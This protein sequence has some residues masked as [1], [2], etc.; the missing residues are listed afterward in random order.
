[1]KKGMAVLGG[2][3]LA[4]APVIV[5]AATVYTLMLPNI[6]SSSARISVSGD[7]PEIDPFSEQESYYTAYNPFFQR[8]QFEIIQSN[9]ILYE[10]INRLNL[11]QEW[12]HN[13]EKLPREVALKI[14]R[15]SVAVFQQRDTSLMVISVKRDRPDEAADIANE[16]AE[17]YRDYRLDS[18][19]KDART[20]IDKIGEALKE[21]LKRVK[22]AEAQ[23]EK[24]SVELDISPVESATVEDVRLQQLEGDRLLAQKEI[25]EK[26]GLL[27]VLKDLEGKDAPEQ[28][29]YITFDPTVVKTLQQFQDVSLQL[30]MLKAD[31]SADPKEINRYSLQKDAIEVVLGEQLQS[32]RKGL[33]TERKIAKNNFEILDQRLAD[34]RSA[35]IELQSDKYRPFRRAQADLETER[36]IYNQLKTKH[37]QE[38]ISLEV[39]RNPVEIIDV[40]E[41]NRRPVSPNL[42]LNVIISVIIAGLFGLAG[43]VLL[44]V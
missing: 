40:A 12:G 29:A 27:Q 2:C 17:T 39:S 9:P 18:A 43:A 7:A 6:Y 19:I 23:I 21:Q 22:A 1:M 28:A 20:S 25:L 42:F 14:L 38:V 5:L 36:F 3:L 30:N 15:N 4:L 11:Q 32:L 10:V 13:G 34:I 16:L 33:E 41:P 44:R 31:S 8:T 35:T 26:D 24:L 37:R